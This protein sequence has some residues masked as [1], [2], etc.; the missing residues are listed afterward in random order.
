MK[1]GV[2]ERNTRPT[3]FNN[4]SPSPTTVRPRQTFRELPSSTAVFRKSPSPSQHGIPTCSRIN[5]QSQ[6]LPQ[7][8][9]VFS[10]TTS[11]HSKQI[12]QI[13]HPLR[14]IRAAPVESS[15][16]QVK[17]HRRCISRG[18]EHAD[19][20]LTAGNPPP[21][22]CSLAELSARLQASCLEL[23]RRQFRSGIENF[24]SPSLPWRDPTGET[25]LQG[26]V[27][28]EQQRNAEAPNSKPARI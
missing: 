16:S 2:L 23:L 21:M 4:S 25:S 20:V 8:R 28:R 6:N 11:N 27:R 17:M 7:M 13:C 10:S 14:Q 12:P 18:D 3:R 22:V 1:S 5:L 26:L 24:N 9:T 19:L 15:L